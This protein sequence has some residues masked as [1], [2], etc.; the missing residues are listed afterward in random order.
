VFFESAYPLRALVKSRNDIELQISTISGYSNI[1]KMIQNYAKALSQNPWLEEFPVVID[2]L[3]LTKNNYQ[4][5]VSWCVYDSNEHQLPLKANFQ[6]GWQ[7]LALSGGYPVKI[8]G[9]WDG[10]YFLPISAVDSSNLVLL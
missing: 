10:E 7:L 1:R 9:E 4:N 3:I 6:K 8:F 5:N 2:S